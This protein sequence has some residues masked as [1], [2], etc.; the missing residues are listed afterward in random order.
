MNKRDNNHLVLNFYP[1]YEELLR[2]NKKNA[3]IRLVDDANYRKGEVASIT[4]GWVED[5]CT[6]LFKAKIISTK[7]KK[8]G[9]LSKRDLEGES[10][11]CK[12]PDVIP[13]I[14]GCIYKKVLTSSDKVRVIKFQRISEKK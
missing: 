10:P 6:E 12:S 11:D 3:T 2:K 7:T 8:I 4:I 9:D 13:Y 14:L 1:Y 5:F